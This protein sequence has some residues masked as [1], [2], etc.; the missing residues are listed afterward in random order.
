MMMY[1]AAQV[2]RAPL[3]HKSGLGTFRPNVD[4]GQ[5]FM[6]TMTRWLLMTLLVPYCPGIVRSADGWCAASRLYWHC[7]RRLLEW[8]E[9]L[10]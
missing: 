2:S 3:S 6:D 9:S 1:M 10:P 5:Q 8:R 7:Q 4:P